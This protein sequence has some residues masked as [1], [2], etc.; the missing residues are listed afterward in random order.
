[1]IA[2]TQLSFKDFGSLICGDAMFVAAS[3]WLELGY[4]PT[5]LNETNILY[6]ILSQS[7]RMLVLH[8]MNSK[9]LAII[10]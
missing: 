9:M 1:L 6:T 8:K 5:S 4:F 3:S 2:L 7:V 10:D